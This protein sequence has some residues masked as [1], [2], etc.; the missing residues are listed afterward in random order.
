MEKEL[1]KKVIDEIF[2]NNEKKWKWSKK[3]VQKLL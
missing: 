3:A 2:E 1:K